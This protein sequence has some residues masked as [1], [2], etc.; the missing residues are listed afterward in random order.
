M[1]LLTT[2]HLQFIV[3]ILLYCLGQCVEDA[4]Y[5][6]SVSCDFQKDMCGWKSPKGFA[7]SDRVIGVCGLGGNQYHCF[8]SNQFQAHPW[9]R[10]DIKSIPLK[11]LGFPVKIRERIRKIDNRFVLLSARNTNRQKREINDVL[12]AEIPRSMKHRCLRY[13]HLVIGQTTALV[14]GYIK[15]YLEPFD[16]SHILNAHGNSPVIK[17]SSASVTLPVGG[18]FKVVFRALF[19]SPQ[20]EVNYG[21]ALITNVSINSGICEMCDATEFSCS[22]SSDECI[23]LNRVCDLKPDCL[24]EEDEKDC[25]MYFLVYYIFIHCLLGDV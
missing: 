24:M 12:S 19:D 13:K 14:V 5:N 18:K 20:N 3:T 17:F 15:D 2:A 22:R 4:D 11:R 23:P 6:N 7:Y 9:I 1:S 10:G 8:L 25:G 21:L 16:L